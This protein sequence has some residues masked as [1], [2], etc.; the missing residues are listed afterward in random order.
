MKVIIAGPRTMVLSINDI[1]Q[2]VAESG[3]TI[4]QLVCGMAEGVDMSALEWANWCGID[5]DECPAKW[6]DLTVSGA[7]I[8]ERYDGTKYNAAA[9]PIRN[10]EMAEKADALI[11]IRGSKATKGTSGMIKLAREQ[12]LKVFVK[13]VV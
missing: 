10:K 3:F 12:G 2:I 5:I 8:R 9:G 1:D 4:D 6:T 11:A 7:V 13:Y